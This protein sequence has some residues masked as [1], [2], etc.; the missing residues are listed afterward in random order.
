MHGPRGYAAVQALIARG[1]WRVHI[2]D[3]VVL[4]DD[5]HPDIVPHRV[6]VVNYTELAAAFKLVFEQSDNRLDFVFAN[7]GILER[8]N[9]YA[10]AAELDEPP[11]EPNWTALDVNLK[12]CMNTIRI[13]RHYMA[14]SP[15]KGSIVVTSSSAA[16]WPS[17]FT[18]VYTASKHGV[19]GF[20]RSIADW[21]YQCDG[22]R[23]NALCPG[24]VRTRILPEASWNGFPAE[25]F[26]PMELVIGIVLKFVDGETIV[27]SNGK[28]TDKD[29]GVTV[30]PSGQNFYLNEV[31][32]YCNDI[33]KSMVEAGKVKEQVSLI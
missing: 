13:A 25:S 7:A 26:T 12:G 27:D 22:I 19:V 31:P 29:H 20:M 8:E 4:E 6:S 15:E 30:V 23:V 28:S 2:F 5:V 10:T 11:P 18:P 14:R 16:I 3:V 1:G 21:Y 17:E 33:H 24:V 32:E 9:W